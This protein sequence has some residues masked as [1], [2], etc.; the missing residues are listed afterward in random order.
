MSS[1]NAMANNIGFLLSDVSRLMRKA[2]QQELALLGSPLTLAQARALL[3][4]ARFEGVRQV[5]I[6]D[7]LE[8][9]P[10]TLARLLDQLVALDLIE[11]RPSPDDRRA[12]QIYLRPKADKHLQTIQLA[13]NKVKSVALAGLDQDLLI[14]QLQSI[15]QKL[16]IN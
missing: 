6:A 16:S 5:D 11:R 2:F 1:N 4:V 14:T 3:I 12:Y 10:I 13:G 8:I 9:Q 7:R 15:Q